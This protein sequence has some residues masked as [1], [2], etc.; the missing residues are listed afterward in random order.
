MKRITL[1]KNQYA[2]KVTSLSNGDVEVHVI[3]EATKKT[4]IIFLIPIDHVYPHS[5]LM[6][7]L[8]EGIDLMLS[9]K[10]LLDKVKARGLK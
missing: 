9:N 8:K 6:V 3:N 4:S 1:L 7:A 5:E 10:E 2:S